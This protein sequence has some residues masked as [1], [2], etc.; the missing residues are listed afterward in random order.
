M[1]I[2]PI[3][4]HGLFN[5]IGQTAAYFEKQPGYAPP[6]IPD[7]KGAFVIALIIAVAILLWLIR[8]LSR[9][10]FPRERKE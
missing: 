8:L 2:V 3:L 6:E 7:G 1:L 5:L 10:D 4:C 9:S